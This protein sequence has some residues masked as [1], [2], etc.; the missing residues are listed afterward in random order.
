MRLKAWRRRVRCSRPEFMA[1]T[2]NGGNASRL[3]SCCRACENRLFKMGIPPDEVK[4]VIVVKSPELWRHRL[5]AH[6]VEKY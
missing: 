4:D 5:C 3:E 2:F 6:S 1:E